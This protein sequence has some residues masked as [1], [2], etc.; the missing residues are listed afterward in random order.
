MPNIE[1]TRDRLLAKV[2]E[3][4]KDVSTKH[5][6]TAEDFEILYVYALVTGQI[7]REIDEAGKE[8]DRLFGVV[9]EDMLKIY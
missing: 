4:R 2:Y 6:A 3:F 7:A 8:I 5:I 1:H 9:D